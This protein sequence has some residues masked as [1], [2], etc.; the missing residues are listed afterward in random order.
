MPITALLIKTYPEGL[1]PINFK[2]KNFVTKHL[3]KN[4]LAATQKKSP[5][6][7]FLGKISKY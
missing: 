7:D 3:R 6:I 4:R 2:L 5:K 1:K